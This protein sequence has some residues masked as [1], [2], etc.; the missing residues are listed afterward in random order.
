V[1]KNSKLLFSGSFKDPAG[2]LFVHKG[3][4]LRGISKSFKRNYDKLMESGLYNELLSKNMLIPHK[5]CKGRIGANW[6]KCIQPDLIPFVSY[7]YE[8][9]FSQY[10]KAALLTLAIEKIALSYNMTLKDAS[11]Y[12]IQFRGG[13]PVFIDTLSLDSYSEGGPW[14]AYQQF[15]KHFLAPLALASYKDVRLLRLL[16]LH[17]DGVPL[18]LASLLLPKKSIFNF[19]VLTH[20][21]LHSLSIKNVTNFK[22]IEAKK[23]KKAILIEFL[24][25]LEQAIK[26]LNLKVRDTH[27]L[28]Y[29]EHTNYSSVAASDKERL[30]SNFLTTIKPKR[31]LDMGA[32][33]GEYSLLAAKK[34]A[35]LVVATD[36]DPYVI[37]RLC[38]KLQNLNLTK[39]LPLVIDVVNPSADI[40]WA[41][42]ERLSFSKRSAFD[43]LFVLALI[44]H[45]SITDN[46]PFA[47]SASYFATLSKNLIIEYVPLRD[48]NSQKLLNAKKDKSDYGWY[49]RTNFEKEYSKFYTINKVNKISDSNRVLYYMTSKIS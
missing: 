20:I 37:D 10:K 12:N 23:L 9:S 30:V 5:E 2:R 21:H 40:G 11:V 38:D 24:N 6:Y 16:E 18:D 35:A 28:D 47:E 32:N 29:Y 4:L 44:H 3:V 17:I 41:N 34:G 1:N 22:N 36:N 48:S 14:V 8:W 42:R 19:H 46:I 25:N 26:K 7:P 39:V 45:L 15:C 43:C 13:N 31:V 27:W 49:T 33:E